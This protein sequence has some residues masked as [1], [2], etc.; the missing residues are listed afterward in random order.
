MHRQLEVPTTVQCDMRFRYSP[1]E[2]YTR[3]NWNEMNLALAK[4]RPVSGRPTEM[5][6]Y[7]IIRGTVSRVD[8]SPPG[9]SEHWVDVYFRESSE[10]ASTSYETSYGAFNVCASDVG[11]FVDM[12]GPDFRSRMI[13]KVLEVQGEFQRNY[14]KGWKGSIRATLARQVHSVGAAK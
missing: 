2:S 10:Q 5:P 6:E 9:A 1:P 3:M 11:I 4:V 7:L 8:V 14:C 12:F 13:G